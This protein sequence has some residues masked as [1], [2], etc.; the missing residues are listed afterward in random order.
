MVV[1][2]TEPR[3]VLV[4]VGSRQLCCRRCRGSASSGWPDGAILLPAAVLARPGFLAW[5]IRDGIQRYHADRRAIVHAMAGLVPTRNARGNR[6]PRSSSLSSR[7]GLLS[8]RST[9]S[10]FTG[11]GG[12][13]RGRLVGPERTSPRLTVGEVLP[14]TRN[15]LLRAKASEGPWLTR[16]VARPED[17]AYGIQDQAKRSP[18][19][20]MCPIGHEGRTIGL[21]VVAEARGGRGEPGRPGRSPAGPDR[22]RRTR[23]A[24]AR[25][26]ASTMSMRPPPRRVRLDGDPPSNRA[27]RRSSSRL[28]SRRPGG[29][30]A[31]RP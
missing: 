11:P 26:R 13:R 5:L 15:E 28:R 31:S 22:G 10:S 16:W 21:L 14:E 17:G 1:A 29:S 12:D 6:R 8:S 30:S 25:T 23:R 19:P 4:P 3:W 24:A 18:R 7:R 20:P 27:S 2:L 9:S